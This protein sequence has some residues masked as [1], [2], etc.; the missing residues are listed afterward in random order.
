M[1]RPIVVCP[2][3]ASRGN[4][5]EGD[6]RAR[7][8]WS[9]RFAWCVDH[10]EDNRREEGCSQLDGRASGRALGVARRPVAA[11]SVRAAARRARR[12][13]RRG[14]ETHRPPA[15]ERPIVNVC[16]SRRSD[17]RCHA[18][19]I[20]RSDRQTATATVVDF[21]CRRACVATRRTAGFGGCR[22]PPPSF[23]THQ[24]R[25]VRHVRSLVLST[26]FTRA[27]TH[28]RRQQS[29]LHNND[30]YINY[31]NSL[32]PTTS[33]R[34]NAQTMSEPRRTGPAD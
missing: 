10:R 15:I 25:V 1:C 5:G 28:P 31:T 8:A 9:W 24:V 33:S 2:H 32:P 6:A 21:E 16:C 27:I 14:A 23:P 26:Y 7:V 29:L 20:A 4:V 3:V 12:R 11:A 30:N 18:V 19:Q 22:K 13:R 17:P 34:N